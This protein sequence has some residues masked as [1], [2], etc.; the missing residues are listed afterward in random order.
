M[1]TSRTLLG[2]GAEAF[3]Y[4]DEYVLKERLRKRYRY[5]TLDETLRK[6]RTRREAKI[7]EKLSS[8]IPVPLLLSVDDA[9]MTITMTHIPG[10]LLRL[11]LFRLDRDEAAPLFARIGKYVSLMHA[12]HIVHG[13][14]TTSNMV[15]NGEDVVL[16]DF[17]LDFVTQKVEDMAVDL[18]LFR[19]A[20]ES[21]HHSM[22]QD[23][24]SAFLQGYSLWEAA[25]AVL[26]RLEKVDSRGRYKHRLPETAL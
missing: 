20:L 16:I 2:Q 1:S 9:S 21:A 22:W 10:E 8:L 11:A 18:H 14:L 24:L 7:M 26:H 15:Y 6:S 13:D 5:S 12:A 3:V 17:G 25:P 23:L 19:Q 4:F